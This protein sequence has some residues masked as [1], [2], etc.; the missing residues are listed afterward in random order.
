MQ[1]FAPWPCTASVTWRCLRASHGQAR[2]LANGV[3]QP[4]KLGEK[5]PVTISATPPAARS[6][7]YA[8]S[9][10]KSRLRSS[11]PVCIEPISTRLRR[12]VKPRSSGANRCGYGGVSAA[13]VMSDTLAYGG[14]PSSVKARCRASRPAGSFPAGQG[15]LAD[16]PAGLQAPVCFPQVGGIDRPQY[17]GERGP[18]LAGFD[19]AADPVEDAVLADHVFGAEAR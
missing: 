12:V 4:S 17:L 10:G 18:Q 11:R 13:G 3:S 6:A 9:L 14:P 16:G 1:I 7:K 2:R 8:A 15:Q 19:Q 5:P